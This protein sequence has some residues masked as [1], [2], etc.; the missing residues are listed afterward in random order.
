MMFSLFSNM[1][2]GVNSSTL[3]AQ[4]S[5]GIPLI[6]IHMTELMDSGA[7]EAMSSISLMSFFKAFKSISVG[8]KNDI[9]INLN[10]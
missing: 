5:K 7:S 8:K 4:N 9:Y 1:F 6:T 3:I 10:V 2:S